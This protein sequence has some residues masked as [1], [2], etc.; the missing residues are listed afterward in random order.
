MRAAFLQVALPGVLLGC[1]A[2]LLVATAYPAAVPEGRGDPGTTDRSLERPP[3][4]PGS[5]RSGNKPESRSPGAD[6]ADGGPVPREL[7]RGPG[8]GP[9]HTDPGRREREQTVVAD[10]QPPSLT[11]RLWTEVYGPRAAGGSFL[12]MYGHVAAQPLTAF[13]SEYDQVLAERGPGAGLSEEQADALKRLSIVNAQHPLPIAAGDFQILAYL[14]G[15]DLETMGGRYLGGNSASRELTV[16]YFKGLVGLADE[17]LT[18]ELQSSLDKLARRWDVEA[19][20]SRRDVFKRIKDTLVRKAQTGLHERDVLAAFSKGNGALFVFRRGDDDDLEEL[21]R[22]RDEAQR[23]ARD[24][25]RL[26]LRR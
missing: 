26:A 10:P 19:E 12:K 5:A 2:R 11:S 6:E 24:G 22:E 23:A 18:P 3:G 4:P 21:L 14:A 9:G 13:S 17:E 16:Q 7:A 8:P 1:A 20:R 15:E 25:V